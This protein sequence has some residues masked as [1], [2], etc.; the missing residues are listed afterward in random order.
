MIYLNLSC[1][2]SQRK[3]LL[4]LD[5]QIVLNCQEINLNSLIP[6]SSY[7]TVIMPNSLHSRERRS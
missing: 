7:S 2:G 1:A 4:R 3:E 6:L 5:Y